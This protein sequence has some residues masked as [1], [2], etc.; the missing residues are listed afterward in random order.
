MGVA[1]NR[2]NRV[3]VAI[4]PLMPMI[5]QPQGQPNSC[6]PAPPCHPPPR[7]SRHA[8]QPL[9]VHQW[10]RVQSACWHEPQYGAL[11]P[12]L[13]AISFQVKSDEVHEGFSR[14]PISIKITLAGRKG[15][16]LT[17]W[18][19]RWADG[20]YSNKEPFPRIHK[21]LPRQLPLRVSL[22]AS[23]LQGPPDHRP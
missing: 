3:K 23:R 15:P 8:P 9:I 11:D 21:L 20:C 4:L 7:P 1:G 5:G 14:G 2:E 17:A 13:R 10:A 16:W 6:S 19:Q 18:E 12:P 22:G